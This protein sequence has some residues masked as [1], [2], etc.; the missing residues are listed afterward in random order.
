M[1]V[2]ADFVSSG[3]WKSGYHKESLSKFDH[4]VSLII[5]SSGILVISMFA[6]SLATITK[7]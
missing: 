4:F 5:I 7:L 2:T 3:A 6:R 1:S